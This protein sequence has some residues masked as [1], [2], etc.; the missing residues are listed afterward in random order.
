MTH[1]Q[2]TEEDALPWTRLVNDPIH[3]EALACQSRNARCKAFHNA[4]R[5]R[6]QYRLAL[7]P[8]A[9][10]YSRALDLAILTKDVVFDTRIRREERSINWLQENLPLGA[11]DP[12]FQEAADLIRSTVSHS[13]TGDYRLVL[14]D[15]GEFLTE[16]GTRRAL[17]QLTREAAMLYGVQGLS[18]YVSF[19]EF[20]RPLY[21]RLRSSIGAVAPEHR[22]HCEK[23]C[24]NISMLQTILFDVMDCEKRK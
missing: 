15:L 5:I 19:S 1:L 6:A 16:D 8:L 14:L 9:F 23:I 4:D 10:S 7:D 22:R 17:E 2:T 11:E 3:H 21:H 12:D 13:F 24:S 20:I 18:F